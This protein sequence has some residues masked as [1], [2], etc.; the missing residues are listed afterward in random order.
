MKKIL[1]STGFS[2]VELIVAIT[3]FA[4]A[5][6]AVAGLISV[7]TQMNDRTSDTVAINSIVENKVESL[8]SKGFNGVPVG[9]TSFSGELPA[10]LPTPRTASYTVS[11]VSPSVK[12]IDITISSG[13]KQTNFKTYLGE[14]GV[15]QY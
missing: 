15:G 10:Y 9:T 11:Q 12:A 4:V 7:L 3:L 8:R 6:P 14:L 13:G 2:I 5:I 1:D